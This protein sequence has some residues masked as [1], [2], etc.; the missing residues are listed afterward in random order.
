[1]GQLRISAC[2]VDR[3]QKRRRIRPSGAFC[4]G[5]M[6][7]AA[8]QKLH[9]H[10]CHHGRMGDHTLFRFGTDHQVGLYD[11]AASGKQKLLHM[12]RVQ[13]LPQGCVDLF[14]R[15]GLT[16][17]KANLSLLLQWNHSATQDS[18]CLMKCSI[19]ESA[20]VICLME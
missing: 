8:L 2:L 4:H 6:P 20:S 11:H 9:R 7:C 1:M 19:R 14:K 12:Q 17:G 16:S 18:N 15:I 13:L 3:S 10:S 5:H